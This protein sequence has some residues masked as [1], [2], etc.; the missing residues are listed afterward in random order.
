MDP[1]SINDVVKKVIDSL[2]E[3]VKA[4]PDE[5]KKNV[6]AAVTAGLDK[7]DVVTREEFDAQ[8]KVLEKTRKKLEKLEAQVDKLC[9]KK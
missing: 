3:G 4:L 2:P 5:M 7:L 6:H 9:K 1:K 8:Q